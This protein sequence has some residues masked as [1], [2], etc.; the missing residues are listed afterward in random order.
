MILCENLTRAFGEEGIFGLDFEVKKG[1]ALCLLG[2]SSAGKSLT[3]SLLMGFARADSGK[4]SIFDMDCYTKRTQIQK[5]LAY[6]P[7]HPQLPPRQ[8]GEE[9]LR[10]ITRYHGG[11]N[12][13]KAR[14]FTERLDVDLTSQGRLLGPEGS[15]KLALL[16]AFCLDSEVM[17]LDEPMVGLSP[18]V[19]D[20]TADAIRQETSAGR[21]VLMTSHILE[22]ARRSCT[23]VAIIRKGRLIISQPVE[24]LA[25]IRQKV[26]HITFESAAQAASFAGEWEAGVE[27]IGSRAMVAIPGSPQVLLQTLQKYT[28]V[29]L[30][31]GREEAEENFL[32]YYGDDLL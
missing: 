27:L 21:A 6:A 16:S 5:R 29:D 18:M 12:P 7:A 13:E 25:A 31:G 14:R 19:R 3:V 22:E 26:Y 10:F 11:F 30:V 1:D 8:T 24:A 2:P 17:I 4:A 9:Y 23:Q 15:K 20:A 28:I 32:R